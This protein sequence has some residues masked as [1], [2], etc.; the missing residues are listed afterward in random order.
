M[1]YKISLPQ[2][3]DMTPT[4]QQNTFNEQSNIT[5]Y[6]EPMESSSAN[7]IMANA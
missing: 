7:E 6:N 4:D 3:K 1:T 2:S 5:F